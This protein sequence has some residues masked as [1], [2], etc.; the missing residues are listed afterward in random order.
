MDRFSR[1]PPVFG[2]QEYIKTMQNEEKIVAD[3]FISD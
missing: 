3:Q 1:T 2:T